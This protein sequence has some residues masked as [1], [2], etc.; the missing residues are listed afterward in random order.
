M[1]GKN[2]RIL[3]PLILLIIGLVPWYYAVNAW[4]AS[5]D[6]VAGTKAVQGV[7]VGYESGYESAP[8]K[9]PALLYYPVV[10]FTDQPGHTQ[11]FTSKVG[12]GG[13]L[14]D[15][16]E[17]IPVRYDPRDRRPPIVASFLRLWAKA[18]L[19]AL[20]GLPFVLLGGVRFFI[21]A[22]ARS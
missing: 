19:F 22:S 15:V 21:A 8:R 18:T 5:R 6:L 3:P 9:I 13:E 12:A 20:A 14:Y 1:N 4:T 2:Q 10:E 16:G 11:R 7:V 17:S